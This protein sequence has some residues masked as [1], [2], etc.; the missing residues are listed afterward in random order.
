MPIWA[1]DSIRQNASWVGKRYYP[2]QE[3]REQALELR[4]L[5]SLAPPPSGR[6]VKRA[7]YDGS[8]EH[9]WVVKQEYPDGSSVTTM[10]KADFDEQAWLAGQIALPYPVP[11]SF[12]KPSAA[13]ETQKPR[14]STNH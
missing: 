6:T 4:Y 12:S 13:A 8:N 5:R 14:S 2:S 10:V 9:D 7:D 1:I 3:D 11:Q